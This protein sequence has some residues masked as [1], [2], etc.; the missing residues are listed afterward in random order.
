[1]KTDVKILIKNI[2]IKK[3]TIVSYYDNSFKR[4][5]T[6]VFVKNRGGLNISNKIFK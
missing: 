3:K 2:K 6:S 4:Y 1:M 5:I